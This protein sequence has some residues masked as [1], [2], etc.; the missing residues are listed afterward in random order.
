MALSVLVVDDDELLRI[1]LDAQLRAEGAQRVVL[2]ADGSVAQRL[3]REEGPF[4][5]IVLDLLMPE[6]DGVTFLRALAAQRSDTDLILTSSLD[7]KI[8]E[9]AESLARAH[10]LRVLGV[11]PKPPTP[12]LL[13]Q[14]LERRSQRAQPRRASA[15]VLPLRLAAA[16]RDGHIQPFF[17]PK[18][19]ARTEA[20]LSVE[21][22]ARWLDPVEGLVMPGAFIAVAEQH[23]MID[24]LT[25]QITAQTFAQ[26]R[27]WRAEGFAPTLQINL[28]ALSLNRTETADEMRRLAAEHGIE[29]AVVTFEITESSLIDHPTLALDTLMRLRMMGFRIAVDDFGV[30]YS[31]FARLKQLP[32]SE[33]KIDMAF[34]AR[35]LADAEARAIVESCVELAIRF[36]LVSVAEGVE[37][38]ATADYL[39]GLGVTMLQGNFYLPAQPADALLQWW[40]DR[41]RGGAAIS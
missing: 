14:L 17:Q 24:A 23:G 29:P 37:D 27:R 19:C 1:V 26:L 32:L 22:L 35:A 39:K 5:L 8:L 12:R 9:T 36:G 31:S 25:R 40:R 13:R 3:L 21:A 34:V 41:P 7:R 10:D 18:I 20:V 30:G 33:L 11:L 28:S 38:L 4:D 2:A 6:A 16:L 15:P